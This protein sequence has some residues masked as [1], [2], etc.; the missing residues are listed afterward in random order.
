LSAK[1]RLPSIPLGKLGLSAQIASLG[2]DFTHVC[3]Q[4]VTYMFQQ[5]EGMAQ[6]LASGQL[7][8]QSLNQAAEQHINSLDPNQVMQH[9]QT[10]AATAQQNGDSGA[11]GML[12]GLLSQQGSNP[13]GLQ[14]E[15]VTI[16]TN[17]PQILQ[18]FLP[19]FAKGILGNL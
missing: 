11:A 1:W 14:G 9:V 8:Q 3:A 18:H 5:I 15:L 19:D 12:T 7:D 10:A 17:N 4:G 13:Q 2:A 16:I 6:Q